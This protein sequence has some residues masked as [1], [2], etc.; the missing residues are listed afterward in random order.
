MKHS[1]AVTGH[2]R[3]FGLHDK[4]ISSTNLDG[5]IVHANSAFEEISGF[6][7]GELI[8]SHHNIVRHPDMPKEAFEVMWSHLKQG[9][10]WMGLVKNRCKNGDHYWVNA[11]V[12]PVTQ[13]GKV[14][15]YESVRSCPS[16][17]DVKRAE[18]EYRKIN[19]K[20]SDFEVPNF[21]KQVLLVLALI[22]PAL[23]LADWGGEL[24]SSIWLGA[25]FF[26]F[27]SLQFLAHKKD[28]EAIKSQ[29]NNVFMH[30][31]A[32]RTYTNKRGLSGKLIVGVMSLKAH[33]DTVL[34]RIEDAA[35][36]VTEQSKTGL[37]NSEA[38]FAEISEQTKQTDL[39]AIAMDEMT[40]AIHEISHNVQETAAQAEQSSEL[41]Q[42]GQSIA[43]T[44]RRSI[45]ELR[46]TVMQIASSVETLVGQTQEITKAAGVIENVS[47]KTN[48]L[49]LNAAIEAARAGEHGR[50]FSVVADEVRSLAAGTKDSAQGIRQIV[51]SLNE[52]AQ[53]S[54][55][56]AHTGAEKA[57]QGLKRVI[58]SESMLQGI[59]S[60][61]GQITSMSE[62][63]AVAV[64]EQAL[65]SSDMNDQFRE[66]SHRA[67]DGLSRTEESANSI[68]L[69]Q[70]V[71]EELHGIVS[72][73]KQ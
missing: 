28:L 5:V 73:F 47:E 34:T 69:S 31:H 20:K 14:V 30:S 21:A 22:C 56:I 57:E 37:E 53:Q 15:G 4:L 54:V 29:L 64:E 11:Y 18:R 51:V 52:Q 59:T 6:S 16:R 72:R 50:G 71:S 62:Q 12:T 24:A 66:I 60:A 7:L 39:V 33:L 25:V 42:G 40:K 46:D 3:R 36:R 63:M 17:E 67:V 49:A 27:S 26:I 44:T 38:A 13:K 2:E 19:E 23:F 43:E 10:P 41:A 68:R 35:V 32:V 1:G 45:E 70:K 9:R 65:V 58:E 55:N 48:L 61:L 8:G